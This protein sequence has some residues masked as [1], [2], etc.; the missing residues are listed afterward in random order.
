LRKFV[1]TER[2]KPAHLCQRQ[3]QQQRKRSR[4][5]DRSTGVQG[6]GLARLPMARWNANADVGLGGRRSST[7]SIDLTV[8]PVNANHIVGR[9]R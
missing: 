9:R 6:T 3:Q 1:C 7:L 8:E 5:V 4:R 2:R